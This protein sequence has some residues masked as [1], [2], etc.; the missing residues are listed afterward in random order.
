VPRSYDVFVSYATTEEAWVLGELKPYVEAAGLRWHDEHA[1]ELG[2]PRISEF[3]RAILDRAC[4]EIWQLRGAH[5]RR[6]KH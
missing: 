4:P 1:F 5:H 6:C 3:E 2:V